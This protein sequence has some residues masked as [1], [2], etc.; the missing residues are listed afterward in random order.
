MEKRGA[1]VLIRCF[2]LILC[3]LLISFNYGA[4][5]QIIRALPNDAYIDS[6][7]EA[8]LSSIG[9]PFGLHYEGEDGRAVMHDMG[10]SLGEGVRTEGYSVT[11]NLFG[12]I[13]IK[14]VS[15]HSQ[16]KIL[17]MPGGQSV[18]VT[19]HTKGALVVGLGSFSNA[20]GEKVCPAQA[21]GIRVGDVI[22]AIKGEEV[23]DSE[24]LVISCNE[25]SGDIKL[26]LS[27]GG[28]NMETTL[29]PVADEADGILKM[30]MWV[31]D[32]TAGIG[33]LSFYSMTNMRYGALGHPIT[34]VDTGAI[35]SVKEGT[36]INSSVVGVSQGASGL[37]GEIRG[38]FSS[39]S[40]R[41]GTLD[42]NGP[43]GI[44]GEL[45]EPIENPLYPN[46]VLLA[47]PDEIHTGPAKLLTT[48][49]SEGVKAYDCEIIKTYLQSSA[50]G[51]GMVIQITDPELIEKTGGIVQGMSGS[52]IIQDGK[53]VG[54]VTHVFVN[55]PLRERK[56]YSWVKAWE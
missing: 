35:L 52:P 26:T 11:V 38:A 51:K 12:L 36:I 44:Y 28:Q 7:N 50:E 6:E 24:H 42:I 27:R 48:V 21:A 33:T 41:L 17:V 37:P 5:M 56:Q 9:A 39:M 19:L 8:S 25:T 2:G 10:E 46:G 30:G 45:Y 23:N 34:D 40:H 49:D 1:A 4:Q 20:Q 31:R 14:Q 43:L 54:A 3:L 22:L 55:D 18:G 47:Y 13:P 53:L 16:D 29:N 15:F 32:S